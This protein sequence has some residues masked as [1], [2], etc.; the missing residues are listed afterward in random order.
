MDISPHSHQC[1]ECGKEVNVD[2]GKEIRSTLCPYCGAT[3]EIP[4]AIEE[5]K[6]EKVF[7]TTIKVVLAGCILFIL[8]MLF[9]ICSHSNVSKLTQAPANPYQPALNLESWSWGLNEDGKTIEAIGQVK[10]ISDKPIA[11][12]QAIIIYYD[13]QNSVVA[14]DTTYIKDNLAPTQAYPFRITHENNPAMQRA[15]VVFLSMKGDTLR[16]EEQK[17]KSLK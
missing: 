8:V 2:E 15:G 7:S 14:K 1:P 9:F 5:S 4:E 6:P 17:D 3:I 16:T 13:K 10:N 11:G 12:V